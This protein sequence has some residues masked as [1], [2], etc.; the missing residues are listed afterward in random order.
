MQRAKR[1]LICTAQVPFVRG[2]AEIMVEALE[3]ELSRRGWPVEVVR[4]P[5]QWEPKEEILKGY[6][7]WQLLDLTMAD[8]RPVDLVITAKFPSFAARHPHKVVWLV[9]QFRQAYDLFGTPYS[10]FTAAPEHQRLRQLIRQMDT[11]MLAEAERLFAISRNVADRLA[12]FNGLTAETLYPPPKF[13]GQ[14]H[15]AAYGDYLLAVSRLDPL[16]RVHLVIEAMAMVHQEVRLLIVGQGQERERLQR[17]AE[18][19]GVAN[20]VEFLGLVGDTQLLD[21][22]ANCFAVYYGPVDEDYGLATL[23]AFKSQKPVITMNDSGGVLEFVEDGVNG[24]IAT[25][26]QSQQ[27]AECISRLYA[28]RQLC[29]QL[30][31]T[32]FDRVRPISWDTA[33][34]RLIE[35]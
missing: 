35:G 18:Q 31:M 2:G 13:E 6:L 30:G 20:R 12:R 28:D 11:Q 24:Y 33:I 16:K 9:Q 21:L 5:F 27:L 3:H 10:D 34:A 23:E 29:R 19:R 1:I 15:C 17:L 7:A 14:Y 8:G 22:Y 26:G 4:I 32:G 25:V